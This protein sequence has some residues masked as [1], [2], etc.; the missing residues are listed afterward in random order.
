MTTTPTAAGE[1][2]VKWECSN[3]AARARK[4]ASAAVSQPSHSA[5]AVGAEAGSRQ[6][7]N[8][9]FSVSSYHNSSLARSYLAHNGARGSGFSSSSFPELK[10]RRSSS[11][12][13]I[14]EEVGVGLEADE[15]Q[16]GGA[17]EG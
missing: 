13:T 2:W 17:E 3:A 1:G 12:C 16:K 14:D 8:A 7:S 6:K 10:M 11:S 15:R 9:T 4:C 5:A